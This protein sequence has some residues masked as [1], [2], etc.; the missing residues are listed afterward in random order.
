MV[1]AYCVE[2]RVKREIKDPN[3]INMK[4]A[5]QRLKVIALV[6][7]TKMLQIDKR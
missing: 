2:R 7:G 6:C 5:N 1:Q 4:I 3:S